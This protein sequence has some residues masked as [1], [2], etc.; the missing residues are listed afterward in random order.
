[1]RHDLA[2]AA[3]AR[4]VRDAARA[5]RSAGAIDDAVLTTIERARPDDRRRQTPLWRALI[6]LFVF[7]AASAVTA[8]AFFVFQPSK[9]GGAALSLVFGVLLAAATE[10]EQGPM[11]LDGTGAEAATS[12]LSL[13]SLVTGIALLLPWSPERTSAGA[14]LA[15]SAVL[16][17]GAAWRWGFPVYALFAA[18]SAIFS[19]AYL[20]PAP[21][22][23]WTATAAAIAAWSAT[24]GVRPT[25]AP[26]L[27]SGGRYALA[28]SLAALYAAVNVYSFDHQWIERLGRYPDAPAS[29]DPLRIIFVAG[30]ALVP[31]AL[32][33][34]GAIARRRLPLD[35]GLVFAGLS[36]VTLRAYVHLAPLWVLLAAAGAALALGSVA[37]ARLLAGEGDAGA[38]RFTSD[39]LFE[40]ESRGTRL[41]AAASAFVLAPKPAPAA[42]RPEFAPGGGRYGG[43]GA[44]GEL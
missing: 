36:L 8:L 9:T 10:I 39:A 38:R 6:F 32:I 13:T 34:A 27:R 40:D 25:L 42:A 22:L 21:R 14:L 3:R 19:A 2:A 41:A 20:L 29:P 44:S 30:T 43:G 16:L 15:M 37:A 5:W 23:A 31:A 12:W 7:V 17:A 11:R 28:G 18:A 4:E 26:P 33:A 1:M 24:R 35:L